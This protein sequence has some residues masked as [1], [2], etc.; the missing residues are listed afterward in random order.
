HA[1]EPIAEV[2]GICSLICL[3][4]RFRHK[5]LL[6][7]RCAASFGELQ[8]TRMKQFFRGHVS[9]TDALRITIG[10]KLLEHMPIRFQAVSPRIGLKNLPLFIEVMVRPGFD[11]AWKRPA[12]AL[13]PAL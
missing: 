7:Q 2:A 10:K 8:R 11:E 9:R 12:P 1:I 5:R 4:F 6:S 13:R 3:R